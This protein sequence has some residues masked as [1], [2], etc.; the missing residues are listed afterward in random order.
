M[1]N[2]CVSIHQPN[3]LPRLGFF[4]KI[5]LSGLDDGMPDWLEG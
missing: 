1:S 5:S 2:I 3:Y 4:N